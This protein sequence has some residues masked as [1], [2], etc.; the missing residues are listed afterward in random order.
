MS[1]A[2]NRSKHSLAFAATSRLAK[3]GTEL[4]S[5][6]KHASSH[7]VFKLSP[8]LIR[9]SPTGQPERDSDP[10][11]VEFTG[12]GCAE[13]SDADAGPGGGE[14]G[15]RLSEKLM[16]SPFSSLSETATDSYAGAGGGED[17]MRLSET[18]MKSPFSSSSE[19]ATGSDGSGTGFRLGLGFSS[20]SSEEQV[21]LR[22]RLGIWEFGVWVLVRACVSLQCRIMLCLKFWRGFGG[23]G[24]WIRGYVERV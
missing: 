24:K 10:W 8:S 23:E 4:W 5:T 20:S 22:R 16:K 18:S 11:P 6:F 1:E 15:V 3:P 13:K 9:E 7:S 19:I 14:G 2:K 12:G 17:G 21:S